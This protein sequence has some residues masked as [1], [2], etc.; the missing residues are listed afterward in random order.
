M[1]H[2]HPH[3]HENN[4]EK[5]HE[6]RP[7]IENNYIILGRGIHLFQ[8]LRLHFFPSQKKDIPA[9]F[10]HDANNACSNPVSRKKP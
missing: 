10:A 8:T 4:L 1:T 6:K 7:H 2:K 3:I 5:T 9:L